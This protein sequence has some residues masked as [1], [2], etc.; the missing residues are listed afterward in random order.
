MMFVYKNLDF[1]K[2]SLNGHQLVKLNHKG[3]WQH[4][5]EICFCYNVIYLLIT[6]CNLSDVKFLG[7]LSNQ[8]FQ[9]NL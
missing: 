8:R 7:M 9:T 1:H 5:M 2:S 6:D 4:I 3:V